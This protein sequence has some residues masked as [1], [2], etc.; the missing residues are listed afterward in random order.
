MLIPK[1]SRSQPGQQAVFY[2]VQDQVKIK[3]KKNLCE[4]KHNL[5][6]ISII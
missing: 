1:S 2:L 5:G 4:G 6:N 3:N